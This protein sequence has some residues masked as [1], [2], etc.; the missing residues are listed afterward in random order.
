MQCKTEG[1]LTPEEVRSEG[2]GWEEDGRSEDGEREGARC[3]GHN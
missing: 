2:G 1:K 3:V